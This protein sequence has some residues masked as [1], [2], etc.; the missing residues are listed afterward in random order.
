MYN[1]LTVSERDILRF[2]VQEFNT[3]S[4]NIPFSIA[5]WFMN[6][7]NSLLISRKAFDFER[8]DIGKTFNEN[9]YASTN[10]SFV[11]MSVGSLNGEFLAL[12]TI[13]QITYDTSIDFLICSD[14]P[15]VLLQ[16][17]TAIE[18]I[19]KKLLQYFTT[20]EV[21]YFDLNTESSKEKIKET[22]KVITM[23]GEISYGEEVKINGKGYLTYSMPITIF[24]TN[25]GEFANQNTFKLGVDE[26]TFSQW[27]NSDFEYWTANGQVG[28]IYDINVNALGVPPYTQYLPNPLNL[29]QGIAS[30]VKYLLDDYLVFSTSNTNYTD[31]VS[32]TYARQ[33]DFN[34]YLKS[35]GYAIAENLGKIYRGLQVIDGYW[36]AT[37]VQN[38]ETVYF[39][40]VSNGVAKMFDIEPIEWHWGTT[41]TQET[42]QFLRD[43]DLTIAENSY[44]V[45]STTKSKAYAFTC[46]LQIDLKEPI[47][48]KLYKDSKFPSGVINKW[49]LLDQTVEFDEVSK[50][51]VIAQDLSFTRELELVVVQPN[52]SL[53]KGEKIVFTIALAPKIKE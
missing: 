12:N 40:T 13:K 48:R 7:E 33:V 38:E 53:S 43:K 17:T 19:R 18:E 51:Y 45:K 21:E 32:G 44:E 41:A 29:E 24:V 5:D 6:G 11:A 25:Y 2:I 15:K 1:K 20:L 34:N 8:F 9:T 10:K 22:L 35:S 26:F 46:D 14:Y 39:Q 16:I 49:Y 31:T 30:R 3:N 37:I 23:T 47:L 50:T 36:Y 52:E 4:L 28:G 27:G 42:T